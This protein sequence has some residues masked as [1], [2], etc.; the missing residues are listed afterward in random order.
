MR[1]LVLSGFL[2]L[3]DQI[4]KLLV[5]GVN[6]PALG[7]HWEGMT[8][9]ASKPILGDFFRLTYIENSGMAFGI[10]LGGKL[11]FSLFSLAASL[12]ILYYLYRSRRAPL[13]FR[14]SLGMILAGAVGN[15]IDRIFYGVLFG[16]GAL[17]HGR[18]VDF[19][20]VDFFDI[21]ILNYHMSRW[22]VFNVAD[23]CVTI[24]V[25]LLLFFHSSGKRKQEGA[26][27]AAPAHSR[28]AAP[29]G[30]ESASAPRS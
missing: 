26:P 20:D 3:L 7:I 18:V 28:D 24:G 12:A 27:D 6:L 29:V 1:V 5:K 9:G 17:F 23:A 19:F 11:F 4:T 8:Y 13:G 16:E 10:D 2:V 30:P 14:V 21:N 25:L 15:L 22:P